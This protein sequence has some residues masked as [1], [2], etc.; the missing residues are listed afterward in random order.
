MVES[1]AVTV[2]WPIFV[3]HQHSTTMH[4]AILFV[5]P[6]VRLSVCLSKT[7][8]SPGSL[9][10]LHCVSEMSTLL[11]KKIILSKINILHLFFCEILIKSLHQHLID[12]PTYL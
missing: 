10:S 7:C 8:M 1:G 4:S 9:V 11:F 6:S 3:V 2:T 12:L 5:F